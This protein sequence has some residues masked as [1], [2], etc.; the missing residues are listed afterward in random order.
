MR[1][2]KRFLVQAI[3]KGYRYTSSTVYE[4]K[5]YFKMPS[6]DYYT[7][8]FD[9]QKYERKALETRISSFFTNYIFLIRYFKS[10]FSPVTSDE[11]YC[12]K[13]MDA[14][15]DELLSYVSAAYMNGNV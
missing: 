9:P 8:V 3:A 11:V 1:N 12:K 5:T 10:P 2:G 4:Q 7:E 14:N 6:I 15:C 13:R